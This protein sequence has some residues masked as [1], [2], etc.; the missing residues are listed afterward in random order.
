[1][2]HFLVTVHLSDRLAYGSVNGIAWFYHQ[3]LDV[4]NLAIKVQLHL[5]KPGHFQMSRFWVRSSSDDLQ[6]LLSI[7]NSDM[8]SEVLTKRT[9]IRICSVEQFRMLKQRANVNSITS[10]IDRS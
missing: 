6:Y 3:Q 9:G 4:V 10:A 1:M 7:S 2:C 5:A 8:L